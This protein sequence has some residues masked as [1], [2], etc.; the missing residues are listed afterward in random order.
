MAR[1]RAKFRED[2]HRRGFHGRFTNKAKVAKVMTGLGGRWD[3]KTQTWRVPK[4]K[5]AE[6]TEALASLG[7][8]RAGRRGAA[9]GRA[10]AAAPRDVRGAPARG[11]KRAKAFDNE[12]QLLPSTEPHEVQAAK[13]RKETPGKRLASGEIFRL[14]TKERK[15]EFGAAAAPVLGRYADSQ[16][17][18]GVPDVVKGETPTE[19][20]HWQYVQPD[21]NLDGASYATRQERHDAITD[22]FTAHAQPVAKGE[23]AQIVFVMGGPASGKSIAE[24]PTRTEPGK[25]Y[26]IETPDG[27]REVVEP[28][29]AVG[30]N[31]DNV[32]IELPENRYVTDRGGNGRSLV[33]EEAS[34][35]S[36]RIARHALDTRRPMFI[37]KVQAKEKDVQAAIDAGRRPR[38]VSVVTS[39]EQAQA[40]ERARYEK[41]KA[42]LAMAQTPEEEAHARKGLRRVEHDR[43]VGDHQA[44]AK[45]TLDLLGIDEEAPVQLDFEGRIEGATPRAGVDVQAVS[46]PRGEGGLGAGELIAYSQ[47]GRV[48]V[49]NIELLE[50]LRAKAQGTDQPKAQEDPAAPGGP[51]QPGGG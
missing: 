23:Q 36:K 45:R 40:N 8:N 30:V 2:L 16:D 20:H 21:L 9:R 5:R 35:L 15:A 50:V 32:A 43:L 1:P 27:G 3:A 44:A 17:L 11:R 31:P 24:I 22:A 38:I 4:A 6:L 51:T 12:G 37:D 39:L 41:A 29:G 26:G 14:R 48:V 28:V 34:D 49:R 46:G 19:D 33:Q 47:D 7:G 25:A 42:L 13:V 18:Y 10:R